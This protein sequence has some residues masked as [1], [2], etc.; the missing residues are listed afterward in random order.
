MN[1]SDILPL[2]SPYGLEEF[3]TAAR[4]LST[5]ASVSIAEAE[6]TVARA[7]GFGSADAFRVFLEG[8]AH[9]GS[10]VAMFETAVERVIDGDIGTLRHSLEAHPQLIYGRSMRLHGATLLH[11]LGANGV[12]NY[13]QRSPSNA[14]A[15]ADLLLSAGAEADAVMLDGTALGLV[16]TSVHPHKAGV[17]IGL[18]ET[19]VAA[20][21]SVEGAAGGWKPLKAAL[22]NGRPEAATWLAAHGAELDLATAAGVGR[23]DV[24]ETLFEGSSDF[25]I[26]ALAMNYAGGYG[27]TAVLRYFV[28][29][30]VSPGIQ[31]GE[32]Y[33]AL[34]YAAHGGHLETVRYLLS[35]DAP[36]EIRNCYGS[37]VLGQ[38]LW[39]AV[40][41]PSD[42]HAEIISLLIA[43][44]A[45]VQSGS[46]RWWLEQPAPVQ[47][48]EPVARVLRS[49]FAGTQ[50]RISGPV[51]RTIPVTDPAR[52]HAF[53][54]DVLGFTLYEGEALYG[55]ARLAFGPPGAPVTVLFP[56][57]DLDAFWDK[58]F[59]TGANPSTPG[60]VNWIKYRV[61]EVVDPDGNKLWFARTYNVEVSPRRGQLRT[62]LPRLHFSDVAAA[63]IYYRDVLGF[64]VNHAQEDFAVM[65]RDKITVLLTHRGTLYS[66]IGS[67]DCYVADV[68]E[69]YDEL[70]GRGATTLGAPVTWPW[71]LRSFTVVDPEGNQV[72][73]HQ[74]FE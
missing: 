37:T 35:V 54:Q 68:D 22:E 36:L 47:T 74:T 7:Y 23:L 73:F 71:G 41:D 39:S 18:M 28:E 58:L 72:T 51:H 33:T 57:A 65:D 11:Y 45:V 9:P 19:L 24:V 46:L 14:V 42:A 29:R 20:G 2:P 49:H 15:M 26:T 16:A 56:V 34:H 13:R 4:R 10:P 27:Q 61:F 38:A 6:A 70:T 43:A 52:S 17:Q 66:G 30:G 55:P 53:Y 40:H 67:Y 62:A 5:D 31:D 48:R 32:H 21:A 1:T 64:S 59:A 50:P 25:L 44:G 69:L 60:K 12:E 3:A 63:L 8:L